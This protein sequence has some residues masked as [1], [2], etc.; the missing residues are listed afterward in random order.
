MVAHILILSLVVF[1][2]VLLFFLKVLLRD[3]SFGSSS[4]EELSRYECGFEQ[5]NLARLPVSIRYFMLTL[6]FLL[7]D[8]EVVLLLLTPFDLFLGFRKSVVILA[9]ISFILILFL[10]LVYE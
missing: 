4:R 6:V 8:L 10:G 5:H 3:T 7:F 1:L 2:V 9:S